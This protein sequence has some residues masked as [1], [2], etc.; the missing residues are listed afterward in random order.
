MAQINNEQEWKVDETE[1]AEEREQDVIT[2]Q[3]HYYPTDLTL[4]GYLDKWVSGQLIIP[5][6]QRQYVWDQVRASKLI[7]S[8]LLGIPVPG[9]F[10]YKERG[11]NKLLVIDGHQRIM[12]SVRYFKNQF[13]ERIFRLKNINKRWN[14]KTFEELDE[15]DRYQLEDTVLRATVVQQLDPKDDSSIYHVFERLNT[16]GM[17]L[18]PMEIRKCIYLGDVFSL[19]EKLN[20]NEA[21]R[22]IIGKVKLDKRLRDVEFILRILAFSKGWR[23]YEKPMK[24]FLSDYLIAKRKMG[25]GERKR[26]LSTTREEFEE[27][28][29]YV[30][31][32]LGAKPFHLRRR[33]NY[34]VMDSTMTFAFQAMRAK[35]TDFQERFNNLVSDSDYFESVTKNTSDEK[36]VEQR[37]SVAMRYLVD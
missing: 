15:P 6:F 23:K 28:C 5:P 22:Q 11:T 1:E 13:D 37:F 30:L 3:I 20:T 10:L 21:W 34:A 7:E 25:G 14:E 26:F 32:H 19:L 8:F 4:K 9:V 29:H 35:V 36:T 17:N 12:T 18:T 27:V 31:Q 2:Y 24:K 16:G 33:L